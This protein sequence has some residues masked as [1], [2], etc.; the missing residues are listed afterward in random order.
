MKFG[1]QVR[2]F[3][4]EHVASTFYPEDRH[5]RLHRKVGTSLPSTI[6]HIPQA[7]SKSTQISLRRVTEPLSFRGVLLLSS[8][9]ANSTNVGRLYIHTYT[10]THTH[11]HK[12]IHTHTHTGM[13]TYIHIHTHTYIHTHT[14]TRARAHVHIYV[15]P[16]SA[17]GVTTRLPVG[18]YQC[19]SRKGH[20]FFVSRDVQNGSGAHPPSSSVGKR[21]SFFSGVKTTVA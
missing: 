6:T 13:H 20:E 10:H 15:S 18:R 4:G 7:S 9:K 16:G 8:N 21:C 11:R 17:V 19:E 5:T 12:Y 14:H 1:T 3:R 2:T